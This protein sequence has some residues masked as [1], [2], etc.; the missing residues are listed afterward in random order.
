MRTKW[1]VYCPYCYEHGAQ[2]NE[3]ELCLCTKY[4][5]GIYKT[6]LNKCCQQSDCGDDANENPTCCGNECVVSL[7]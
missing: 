4:N 1:S 7:L 3:N 5:G 6:P 2:A